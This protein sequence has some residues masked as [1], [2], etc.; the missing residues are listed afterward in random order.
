MDQGQL[1]QA[2]DTLAPDGSEIRL[3]GRL[4]GGSLV[5]CTLAPGRTSAAVRH[6]TVEEL[7][8]CVSGQGQVWRSLAGKETEVPIEAGSWL[9]V[10]L[11]AHFQFRNTGGAPLKLVIATLP[12]WPGADEAE[13]VADRWP[14]G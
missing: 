14:P 1:S 6:R 3:A 13:R 2:P 10:P 8:L 9:T 12:P 5:E 4:R 11:G 7:W